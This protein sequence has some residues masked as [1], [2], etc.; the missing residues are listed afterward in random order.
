MT[1]TK[2]KKSA[3]AAEGTTVKNTASAKVSTK[4]AASTTAKK[5]P[6]APAKA[7]AKAAA[8]AKDKA[9]AKPTAE[10]KPKAVVEKAAPAKA[11]VS[12]TAKP[13][14]ASAK[15]TTAHPVTL[16]QR[17]HYIEVAAYYI[18]ER[19]GFQGGDAAEDW[20]QAE[21]EIDDLLARGLLNA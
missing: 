2:P 14:K 17:S 5:P 13:R 8:S 6:K 9:A 20:A 15:A 7:P 4:A 18:A 3:V 11:K 16:E 21:R 10:K 12:A 1:T 19:R